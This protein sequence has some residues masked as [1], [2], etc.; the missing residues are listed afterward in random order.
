MNVII[1]QIFLRYWCRIMEGA[2]GAVEDF[3]RLFAAAGVG[4]QVE[5]F[6]P[7]ARVGEAVH[8]G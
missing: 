1:A 3:T 8:R 6:F 2:C 5:P 4:M 7:G